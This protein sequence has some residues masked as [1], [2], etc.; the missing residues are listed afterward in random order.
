MPDHQRERFVIELHDIGK[1]DD[2]PAVVRLRLL[3]KHALRV[4]GLRCVDARE[5][6]RVGTDTI[7]SQHKK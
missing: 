5:V 1:P 6:D 3:L 7:E 2:S 4:L